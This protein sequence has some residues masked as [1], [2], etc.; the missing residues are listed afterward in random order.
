M[1]VANV[2]TPS[3]GRRAEVGPRIVYVGLSGGVDSSVAALL[4]L[5]QGYDVRGVY[6]KTWQPEYIECT[7]KA[8]RLDAMRVAAQL[9]IPFI[10]LDL[11]AEYKNSVVDYMINEY[12]SGHTPNPDIMCNKN[13]K[14]GAFYN[15]VKSIDPEALIATGHYVQLIPVSYDKDIGVKSEKNEAKYN[16]Q[17]AKDSSKDQV[18][19]LTQ[20][21]RSLWPNI[22]FPLGDMLKSEVRQI[23]KDNNLYVADKKDS[24]GICMLGNISMKDFLR[25]EINNR[26]QLHQYIDNVAIYHTIGEKVNGQYVIGKDIQTGELQLADVYKVQS[27]AN[28]N[29]GVFYINNWN[30]S[31]EAQLHIGNIYEGQTRYHGTIYKFKIDSIEENKLG[32]EILDNNTLM[33]PGQTLVLYIDELVIGGGII[34]YVKIEN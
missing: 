6:I 10:T 8:D 19:F 28:D 15:Y 33:V 23:A 18:Y 12:V 31:S 5:Q 32:I 16:L 17:K 27:G 29:V 9:N 2:L 3:L 13:I 21:D 30:Y 1:K 34:D 26:P 22:I 20:V 11:E 25:Q 4:L 7:W 24:Q 14:F